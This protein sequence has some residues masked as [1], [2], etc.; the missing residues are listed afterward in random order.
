MKNTIKLYQLE[1]MLQAGVI[2]QF[3]ESSRQNYYVSKYGNIYSQ[4]KSNPEKIKQLATPVDNHGYPLVV[5]NGKSKRVH[6]IVVEAFI[7]PMNDKEV[8]NHISGIKNQND[9]NNLE[10]TDYKGNSRHAWDTGLITLKNRDNLLKKLHDKRKITFEDAQEIRRLH[11][12]ESKGN[13]ELS[14]MY[15]CNSNTIK[16]ILDNKSYKY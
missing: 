3:D 13:R 7:R 8:V 10:I 5:T 6:R 15:D 2:K 14:R 4:S 9:L 11:K 16:Q 12:E 1:D